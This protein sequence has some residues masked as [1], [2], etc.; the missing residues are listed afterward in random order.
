MK[1]NKNGIHSTHISFTFIGELKLL[2]RLFMESTLLVTA[3]MMSV[4]RHMLVVCPNNLT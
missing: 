4:R 1:L 2:Q 3:G